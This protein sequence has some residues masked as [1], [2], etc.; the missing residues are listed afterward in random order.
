MAEAAASP[1]P[2]ALVLLYL[3]GGQDGLNVI[4]P[5]RSTDYPIYVAKRPVLHRS[6]GATAG[7]VVGSQLAPGTGGELS[8]ANPD[9]LERRRRRQRRSEPRL[10]RDLRRRDGGA[11]SD[12]ALLPAIDYMPPNLSH[13][14]CRTI[15]SPVT[16]SR[17]RPAGSVASSML[18]GSQ[19]NPLQGISIGYSLSKTL[20][21]A[22]APV[23][24][25]SSLSTLGFQLRPG[26]GSPGGDPTA[27][28]ANAIIAQLGAIPAAPTTC[29]SL[30][31][32]RA[33]ELATDVHVETSARSASPR[34]APAI[35]RPPLSPQLAARRVPA[36]R[37]SS[38]R[39]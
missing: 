19:T 10:R 28:N 21:T 14:T 27:V 2:N 3:A 32:A 37:Q 12:L 17:S 22:S 35:R 8:F 16:S 30:T 34:S 31:R 25:I 39:A 4:V 13:F 23:C 24:T 15:G 20:L 1:A 29:S 33:I 38:A 36:C 26:D 9:C 5:I 7:G 18:Y 6:Q 11:G